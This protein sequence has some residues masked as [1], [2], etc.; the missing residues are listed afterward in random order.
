M[1]TQYQ[2]L[3]NLLKKLFQ[4]DQADLDF[5]IY[6]IINQRRT[7]INKFL[8]EDLLPQVQAAFS[9]YQSYDK[10]IL[11]EDLQEAIESAKKLGVDPDSAP[12]VQQIR[13]RMATYS[14]DPLCL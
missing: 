13:E 2:K 12:K 11:E 7:E 1:S 4:S 5:G 3:S 10:E 6:R 14:V 9:E 8:D